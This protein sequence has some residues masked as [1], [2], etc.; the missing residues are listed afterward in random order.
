MLATLDVPFADAAVELAVDAAVES[1]SPLLVVNVVA[2][3]FLPAT[4]AG[5]DYVVRPEIEDSLRRPCELAPALGVHVERLR[6]RSPH[7]LRALLELMA[8]RRPGLLVFGADRDRVSRRLYRRVQRALE[9][10]ENCL[11]WIADEW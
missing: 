2:T 11:V 10:Q 5:W 9:S 7:P 6:V 8:E 3:A 1:G 4:L